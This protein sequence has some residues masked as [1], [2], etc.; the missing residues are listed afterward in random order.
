M[1]EVTASLGRNCWTGSIRSTFVRDGSCCSWLQHRRLPLPLPPT[2]PTKE[3]RLAIFNKSRPYEHPQF[4]S[5]L[6]RCVLRGLTNTALGYLRCLVTHPI[7]FIATAATTASDLI[8][9]MP[10]SNHLEQY[11]TTQAFLTAFRTWRAE[12]ERAIRQVTLRGQS[13]SSWGPATSSQDDNRGRIVT[14]AMS[15]AEQHDWI[16]SFNTLFG[17]LKGDQDIVLDACD[18]W[19]EALAVWT[20]LVRPGC[21]R[22]DLP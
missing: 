17:L 11:P 15:E 4:W 12:V 10:R 2:E 1:D 18:S 22:D 5:C 6:L 16:A 3:E 8:T 9:R 21:T 14:K 7:P 13:E 19:M 20:T